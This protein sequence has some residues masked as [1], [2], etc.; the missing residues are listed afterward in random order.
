MQWVVVVKPSTALPK[1]LD[2][3]ETCILDLWWKNALNLT[4]LNVSYEHAWSIKTT[5]VLLQIS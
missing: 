2:P 5:N 4:A 3:V 1:M